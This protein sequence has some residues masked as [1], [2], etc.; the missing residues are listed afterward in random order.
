MLAWPPFCSPCPWGNCWP[1]QSLLPPF[2]S[3]LCDTQNN[4]REPSLVQIIKRVASSA[5]SIATSPAILWASPTG[6]PL[7]CSCNSISFRRS[8]CVPTSRHQAR[9]AELGNTEVRGQRENE[10]KVYDA[11]GC[12]LIW[13]L[14]RYW[15]KNLERTA[16]CW[17]S[18]VKKLH[19]WF[20]ALE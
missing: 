14:H 17:R 3:V 5:P 15:D 18:L 8:W 20:P 11:R 10:T 1:Q 19:K 4:P 13:N 2:A 12:N 9:K 7:S 6:T 16:G